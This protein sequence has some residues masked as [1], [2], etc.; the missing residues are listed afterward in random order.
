M[1]E[2]RVPYDYER[3][4]VKRTEPMRTGVEKLET[5]RK[6]QSSPQKNSDQKIS[7]QRTN[8]YKS[9]REREREKQREDAYENE[10]TP[11]RKS[12]REIRPN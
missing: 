7:S 1:E 12:K 8:E 10:K 3:E 4:E 6:L 2:I 9:F 5:S 11:I